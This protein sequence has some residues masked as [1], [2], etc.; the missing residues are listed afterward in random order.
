MSAGNNARKKLYEMALALRFKSFLFNSR[1][2][3]VNVVYNETL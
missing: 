1:Y 3:K 2:K